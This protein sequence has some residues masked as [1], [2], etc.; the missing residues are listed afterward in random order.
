MLVHFQHPQEYMRI[1]KRQEK[2][3]FE[4]GSDKLGKYQYLGP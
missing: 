3:G 2:K 4:Y 1:N